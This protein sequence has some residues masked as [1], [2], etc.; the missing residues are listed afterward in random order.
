MSE[1]NKK[2]IQ[3][4]SQGQETQKQ[5]TSLSEQDLKEVS[6]GASASFN[7]SKIQIEY[8]PQKPDGSLD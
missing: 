2:E 6:G 8:K 5:E 7:F 1:E 3:N 4:A